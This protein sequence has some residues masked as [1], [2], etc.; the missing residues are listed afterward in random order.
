M[1]TMLGLVNRGLRRLGPCAP[2]TQIQFQISKT[3]TIEVDSEW[4]NRPRLEGRTVSELWI[5]AFRPAELDALLA[6]ETTAL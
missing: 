6:V 2:S 3:K 4:D 1:A 5:L